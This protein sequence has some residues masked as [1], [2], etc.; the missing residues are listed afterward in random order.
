MRP[1]L[2]SC[3]FP[4]P[5]S[6]PCICIP[7][8]RCPAI[9]HSS[10]SHVKRRSQISS[11]SGK[12]HFNA[13]FNIQGTERSTSGISPVGGEFAWWLLP[14]NRI[15]ESRIQKQPPHRAYIHQLINKIYISSG[16]QATCARVGISNIHTHLFMDTRLPCPRLH[17]PSPDADHE[18]LP[19]QDCSSS[20]NSAHGTHSGQGLQGLPLAAPNSSEKSTTR[21]SVELTPKSTPSAS[22]RKNG[23]H[24][25]DVLPKT[26]LRATPR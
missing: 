5:A 20:D 8:P 6:R 3:P 19:H 26:L 10:P 13:S 22:P 2:P 11:T 1:S 12:R 24:G 14:M 17:Q 21:G 7:S 16:P 15:F 23:L 25:G 18:P 9:H 4:L